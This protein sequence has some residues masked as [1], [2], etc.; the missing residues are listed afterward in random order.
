[1]EKQARPGY[2]QWL[3]II[4][5][6]LL[7]LPLVQTTTHLFREKSLKGAVIKPEDVEL[8]AK[9]W[10]DDTYQVKKEKYYNET[11]GFRSFFVRINNQLTLSLFREVHAFSVIFGKE[12]YL[13]GEDYI[14]TCF[15]LDF[16]GADSIARRVARLKYIQDELLNRYNKNLMVVLAAGKGSYFPEYFPPET[17]YPQGPTNYETHVRLAEEAGLQ[18]IDFNRWFLD[19]K[20]NAPYPLYPRHGLHWSVYG[21]ALASDSIIS[22]IENTR[23]IDLPSMSW[24]RVRIKKAYQDDYD[25]GDVLNLLFKLRRD[26]LAYPVIEFEPDEGKVK[27]SVLV[28][29]DSF[30][31][32]LFK[33]GITRAFSNS[34]FWYYNRDIYRSVGE[35]QGSTDQLDLWEEILKHDVIILLATESNLTRFGWGFIEEAAQLLENTK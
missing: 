30:Y 23:G 10:F 8:T 12:N 13:F 24:N 34:D 33:S 28:I 25:I 4:L 19:M 29:A 31:W 16:I 22:W 18:I 27:P 17:N 11:F 2:R 15:G 32:G 21:A 3:F 6:I 9:N 5:M 20:P 26:K 14:K 7:A 1:M 35:A